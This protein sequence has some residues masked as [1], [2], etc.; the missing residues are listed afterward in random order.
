VI[1][2]AVVNLKGGS[3]KTTTSAFLAHAFHESGMSVLGVDADA[4]NESLLSWREDADWPFPVIALPVKDLHKQVPGIAGD[5]YDVVV[6]DTPPVKE[7]RGIV[8]SAL[9]LATHVVCPLAPTSMEHERLPAVQEL[10]D[11]A[12]D[13][14][15][16]R[17]AF[18]VLLTRTVSG[19]SSTKVYRELIEAA[20]VRVLRPTIGRLERYAQAYGEPITGVLEG[21][22]YGD[23]AM[24]LMDI[25]EEVQPA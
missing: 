3:T 17:P 25:E 4:E 8:L 12:C 13:M 20:G 2:V 14:R 18:A 7:R 1:V 22:A 5:R 9:R 24:E 6:I 10:L 19:A 23:A 11:E 16:G 15:E 21:T